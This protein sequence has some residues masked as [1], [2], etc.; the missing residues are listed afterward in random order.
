MIADVCR[1]TSLYGFIKGHFKTA[2]LL[3]LESGDVI[4]ITGGVV[5]R[6]NGKVSNVLLNSVRSVFPVSVF[7][8]DF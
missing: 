1:I 5:D 3:R 2:T 6:E 4:D 7:G 8:N